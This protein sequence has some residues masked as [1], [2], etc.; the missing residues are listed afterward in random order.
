[1]IFIAIY[2]AWIVQFA[3][4]A[5][6][7]VVRDGVQFFLLFFESKRCVFNGICI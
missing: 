7:K 2:W 6:L 4:L 1:M 5:D 3:Y